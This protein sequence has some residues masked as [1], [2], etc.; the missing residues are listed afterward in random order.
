M[1]N[2][3]AGEPFRLMAF[4]GHR[5]ANFTDIVILVAFRFGQNRG[6]G[7]AQ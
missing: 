6:R 3:I 5:A 7:G 1:G 2:S 4:R